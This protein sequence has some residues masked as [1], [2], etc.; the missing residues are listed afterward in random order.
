MA[1][2]SGK[3]FIA[4]LLSTTGEY[5]YPIGYLKDNSV[6][7]DG[8]LVQSEQDEP[9][10]AFR[11]DFIEHI[12]DR[13]HYNISAAPDGAYGGAKV[14]VS[15]NGYL[16]FYQVAEVSDYWK[17][18]LEGD[19]DNPATFE[20][21]LRDQRGHRVAAVSEPRGGFWSSFTPAARS[22]QTLFLN[23][24]IGDIVH[25]QGRILKYL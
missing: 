5:L 20:F 10:V 3:S 21:L 22:A 18:E 4:T 9:N 24:E 25:F 1:D 8:W 11:F 15:R 16:G 7:G 13:I 17:V 23:T 14:G 6:A 2:I 19:N 12:G